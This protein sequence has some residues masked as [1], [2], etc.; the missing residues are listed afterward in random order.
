MEIIVSCLML[1]VGLSFVFKLTL[2]RPLVAVV[3]VVAAMLFTGLAWTWA[4]EQS[5]TQISAWL[6]DSA[7]MLDLSVVLSFDVAAMLLYCR[8]SVVASARSLRARRL[9][10]VLEAYP[11]LLVFPVLFSLLVTLIFSLPG[12]DFALTAWVLA[13][14]LG[15]GIPALIWLFSWLLPERELRLEVLFILN[16]MIALLGIV[17]TVNGRTA[18]EAESSVN[19]S[20][21]AAVVVLTLVFA[22]AGYVRW[23]ILIRKNQKHPSRKHS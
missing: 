23:R 3:T 15:V 9:T 16:V 7:L 12:V 19:R 2:A 1:V 11:G 4:A 20:A 10:R 21:L 6:S 13:A 5:K 8:L 14:V 22:L 18:V 17:A